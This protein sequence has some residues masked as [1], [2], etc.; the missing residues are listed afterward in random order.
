MEQIDTLEWLYPNEN[1]MSITVLK[2]DLLWI[3]ENSF[4]KVFFILKQGFF[5][6]EKYLSPT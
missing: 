3:R 6:L 5:L 2:W 4:W 1:N